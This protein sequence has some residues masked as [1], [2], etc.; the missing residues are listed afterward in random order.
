MSRT[1][2]RVS[3]R[4]ETAR[5]LAVKRQHLAGKLPD[6][7]GPEE[8][9][10]VLRDLR[11]LQLDPIS[12]V[13]PS[14]LLVLWS[15][16]GQFE[17]PDLDRLLWRDRRLFEDMCHGASIVL[18]EDYPLYQQRMQNYAKTGLDWHVR[19]RKWMKDNSR[20]KSYVLK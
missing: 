16:L 14:H 12:A 6:K 7:P 20:L 18:M 1:P 19:V 3:V 15:R 5:R 13:A 9:L 10:R 4:L 8:I 17:R 11:Y 2:K